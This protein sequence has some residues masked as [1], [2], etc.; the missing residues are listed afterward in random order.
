WGG[1]GSGWG[2]GGVESGGAGGRHRA[3]PAAMALERVTRTVSSS[4]TLAAVAPSVAT[5]ALFNRERIGSSSSPSLRSTSAAGMGLAASSCQLLNAI[6][7][8]S[9]R[10]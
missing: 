8:S 4:T 5:S 2:G 6:I 9:R 1:G 7:A 3:A 10:S